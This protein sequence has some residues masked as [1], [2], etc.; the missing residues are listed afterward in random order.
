MSYGLLVFAR[1][2][3]GTDFR[4]APRVVRQTLPPG[5]ENV[6]EILIKRQHL[7]FQDTDGMDLHCS[8]NST[9]CLLV[10]CPNVT[11]FAFDS[12]R[13]EFG[14]VPVLCR[15]PDGPVHNNSSQWPRSAVGWLPGVRLP[16]MLGSEPYTIA[17]LQDV[18]AVE[19]LEKLY[20]CFVV[21]RN[22]MSG[23]G[24]YKKKSRN[25]SNG[26]LCDIQNAIHAIKTSDGSRSTGSEQYHVNFRQAMNTAPWKDRKRVAKL[27]IESERKQ[28]SMVKTFAEKQ[29]GGH[30]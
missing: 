24:N 7:T 15:Y 9:A 13:Q 2:P 18:G 11:P 8:S 30:Y 4:F 28:K 3:K 17:S 10:E 20:E 22:A 25:S 19:I 6:M 5:E 16:V 21:F 12:L 27:Q 23:S 14:S 26:A 1:W 29:K